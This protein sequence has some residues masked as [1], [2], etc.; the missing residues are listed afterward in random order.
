MQNLIIL[1]ANNIF[2]QNNK[3]DFKAYKHLDGIDM[4]ILT[5]VNLGR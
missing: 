5:G 2:P 3:D 1:R 4:Q